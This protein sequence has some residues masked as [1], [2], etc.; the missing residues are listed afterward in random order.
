MQNVYAFADEYGNNSFDFDNQGTNFVVGTIIVKQENLDY[1]LEQV[2]LIRKKYFQTGEI[3][4][5]KVGDNS[6]RRVLILQDLM[7]LDFTIYAVVVDKKRLYG[8]G[9]KYKKSFYKFCCGLVYRELFRTFP[10]L[11]ITVDEHGSN[12]FMNSFKRYI[13]KNH[14]RDLFQGSEL[15]FTSSQKSVLIQVAD[16]IT[17]T[18]GRV[19]DGSK[20]DDHKEIYLQLLSRNTSSVLEYPIEYTSSNFLK[21]KEDNGSS[22]DSDIATLGIN[23]ALDFIDKNKGGS[24]DEVDKINFLRLLLL[25]Q[26]AYGYNSYFKTHVL[27]NHL[28]TQREGLITL[29]YFRTKIIGKLRDA[30]V[31][32]ASNS[33]G[34][35]SGYKLPASL[36]DIHDY[37]R[38]G[39]GQ[40]LPMLSRIKIC[41]ER[42]KL[43]THNKLDILDYDAFKELKEIFE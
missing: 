25:Y 14:R 34:A 6:K 22:F 3:K 42:V 41:R 16:F 29:H 5:S 30:G 19:Y 20:R 27:L 24:K 21:N 37:I 23:L 33:S 11:S 8:D 10:N 2:E 28:N 38:H 26:K 31:L 39:H 32:I 12:E 7:K 18:I 17:G 40:I 9:F 43:A 36:N 1:T 13:E 35:K 15:T 4:S